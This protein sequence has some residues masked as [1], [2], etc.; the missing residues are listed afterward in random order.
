MDRC[1]NSANITAEE[2]MTKSVNVKVMALWLQKEAVKMIALKIMKI[3]QQEDYK[4]RQ[5]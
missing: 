1:E 3:W 4:K 2:K 5:L